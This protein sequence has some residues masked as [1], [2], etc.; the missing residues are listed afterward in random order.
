MR[1]HPTQQGKGIGQ[2]MLTLLEDRA[3]MNGF[4]TIQLDTTINQT[5]AIKLYERN[6]YKEIRRETEGWP[7]EMIFYQKGLVR[8]LRCFIG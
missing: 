2:N 1:V 3:K 4:R 6:G 7:I 8:M 5:A